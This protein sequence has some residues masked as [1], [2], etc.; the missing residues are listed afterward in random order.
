VFRREN[1]WILQ[2]RKLRERKGWK[3]TFF[4]RNEVENW[5]KSLETFSRNLPRE[6]CKGCYHRFFHR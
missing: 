1:N 5:R 6:E 2:N 3:R 4:S